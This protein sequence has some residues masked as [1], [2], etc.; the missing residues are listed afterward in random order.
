MNTVTKETI[1]YIIDVAKLAKSLGI[2][3]VII[4]PDTVRALDDASTVCLLQTENV[5]SL[6]FTAIG[7]SKLDVLL[8]RFDIAQMMG[9]PTISYT[10]TKSGNVSLTMK[11]KR[12]TVEYRGADP[13]QFR[14]P[15]KINDN[16]TQ[17]VAFSLELEQ[18]LRKGQTAM[19]ADLV[20]I[21]YKGGDSPVT[22]EMLD[23]NN[24]KLN[25]DIADKV[26][27]LDGQATPFAHK[28]P[29]K[30]LTTII[31]LCQQSYFDVGQMR[32]FLKFPTDKVT[33]YLLPQV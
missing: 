13:A 4:E 27:V 23:V 33:T 29:V 17:R 30:L 11:A 26:E 19:G 7:L 18:I 2:E 15:R 25:F 6:E 5:P 32:G 16:M 10:L 1:D 22:L 31:K 3:G 12:T 14:F 28:Y 9:A 20:T 21:M 24:D 8:A